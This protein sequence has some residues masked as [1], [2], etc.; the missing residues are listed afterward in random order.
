MPTHVYLKD[1]AFG[2]QQQALIATANARFT[3]MYV[4]VNFS[5]N[6]RSFSLLF[7]S[8]DNFGLCLADLGRSWEH[9]R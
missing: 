2:L 6:E 1:G 4:S 3:A 9:E 8:Q 7:F 5:E